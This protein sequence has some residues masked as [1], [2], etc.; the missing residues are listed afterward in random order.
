MLSFP[1]E[2]ELDSLHAE[3]PPPRP[4]GKEAGCVET[5]ASVSQSAVTYR[6]RQSLR[7]TRSGPLS[8]ADGVSSQY[9][10]E[11]ATQ[12]PRATPQALVFPAVFT[13]DVFS[14]AGVDMEFNSALP[15]ARHYLEN[16]LAAFSLAVCSRDKPRLSELTRSVAIGLGGPMGRPGAMSA[17]QIIAWFAHPASRTTQT[18]TNLSARFFGNSVVYTATYQDWEWESG[19]RCF[20]LGAYRGRLKAGPTVWNWEEHALIKLSEPALRDDGLSASRRDD[21]P[22]G[23]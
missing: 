22:W 9:F 6:L 23:R 15:A 14:A 16:L 21:N 19:P 4:V 20:A 18:I 5:E 10:P 2:P 11:G 12:S 8:A 1:E 7:T 3:E 13:A 17:D